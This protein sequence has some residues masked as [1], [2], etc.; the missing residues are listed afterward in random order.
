MMSNL[1]TYS[2]DDLEEAKFAIN[3]LISKC[4]KSFQKIAAKSPQKTLLLRR[5]K[6]LKISAVLIDNELFKLSK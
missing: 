2:K 1:T 5:I 6:A 4:E 3:S